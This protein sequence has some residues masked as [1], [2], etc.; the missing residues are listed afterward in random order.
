MRERAVKNGYTLK[1]YA[2]TTGVMLAMNV[3]PALR[4]EL[5]GFAIEREGPGPGRFRWLQGLLRFPSQP[6]DLHSPIESKVAPIQKFRWSDYSVYPDS[7]YTYQLYAVYGTP[8]KLRYR[9]GPSV[10][11]RTEALNDGV[12]QIIFNRAAAASQAYSSRFKNANPDDPAN[13]AARDWLSRGLRERLL[14][15]IQQ[16]TDHTW[17][18]DLAIYEIEMAQIVDLLQ[19]ALQR[20]VAVRIVYHAREKDPQTEMNRKTLAPLP[21][22]VLQGRET[23]AIFHHKFF[24]LSRLRSD[25]SR[26]PQAVLTGSTN[27]TDQAVYRQANVVHIFY[28]ADIAANYLLLFERLFQG[29]APEDTKRFINTFFP[30]EP[31]KAPQAVFSPRSHLSDLQEVVATV[32]RSSSDLLFCTAF[33]LHAEIE[34]ALLGEPESQVIR[35]GLQ[36]SRSN[37]TGVHRQGTFVTPAFLKTGLEGFLQESYAG[38]AGNIFIHLKTIVTDFTTHQPTIITGS[39]NF[40]TS[41][42]TSNDENMLLIA[43]DTSVADTYACEMLRLYDHYRFRFNQQNK[44]NRGPEGRLA[45][46]TTDAWT[47]RYF[48]KGTLACLERIRFSRR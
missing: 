34:Q 25:G 36:N 14:Q 20:G 13:Q 27:F 26:V 1:A 48:K 44:Y 41:A 2:G 33:G 40:S 47:H 31:G 15:F 4:K 12:H 5:L 32:R 16:A 35:Y 6:R 19:Q 11:V 18:L 23:N 24:V 38:Q 29:E 37:I 43:D 28:A 45:L 3:Q 22:Q 46:A 17:A 39:N 7:P 21:E 30:V 8:S 10:T 42:S 9:S